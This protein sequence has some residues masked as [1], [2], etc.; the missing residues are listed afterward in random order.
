MALDHTFTT[1]LVGGMGPHNWTCVVMPESREI[2]G[3]SK[4]AKV[5]ATVDGADFDATLLPH[6]GGHMLA[7]KQAIQNEIGKHAGDDVTVRLI[8]T[9]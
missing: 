8:A 2:L 9:A 5:H 4:A 1:T 7:I 6:K 3:T